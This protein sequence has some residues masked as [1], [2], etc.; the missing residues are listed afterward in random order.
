VNSVIQL[1]PD[2]VANQIAAGEVVQRPASAIKEL[3]ENSLDAGA[4][5][6]VLLIRDGGITS[7]QVVD[8]GRGMSEFDARLCWERHAT[9]KIRRAEDLFSLTTYGFR[10]EAMASIAAVAQVEMKTRR[11]TD[12]YAQFIRIE[13]SEV[14]EQRPEAAPVGTNITIKNLFYNIPARRNFLKSIPVETKHIVEEFMR[15]AM[16]NSH[17][18][19]AFYN[20]QQEVYKFPVQP[21][22]DRL[23]SALGRKKSE[24]LIAVSENT[25]IVRISGFVGAPE[26]AK[27]TRGDQYFF[28]NGRF[29]R[30]SYFHHA[31]QGAY[32]GLI[33]QDTHAMYALF[34]EID[35]AKVDVNVH[36]TK[37]E[38]KFEDEKHLYN[39]LKA[40]VRKSLGSFVIQP[41]LGLETGMG[42]G[43]GPQS[44]NLDLT[45]NP[46]HFE[47]LL[48]AIPSDQSGSAL[49]GNTSS[50]TGS[51]VNRSFNPFKNEDSQPYKREYGQD[52]QRVLGS[53]ET[54]GAVDAGS[55]DRGLQGHDS[56][57]A[58]KEA[59]VKFSSGNELPEQTELFPEEHRLETKGG[60]PLGDLYWVLPMNHKLLI[61]RVQYLQQRLYFEKYRESLSIKKGATQ[62]LLFPRMIELNPSDLALA[63]DLQ[64]E[65]GSLGFDFSHFGGNS[66]IVNGLPPQLSQGDEQ[67]FLEKI[68]EDYLHTGGDVKLDRH[69]S[70]ALTM[71][72]FA[73]SRT[74]G[75]MTEK[76][77]IGLVQELFT[78]PH[79]EVTFDGKV[80]FVEISQSQLFE[81]FNKHRK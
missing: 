9:S 24:D 28:V 32:E 65:L 66:I 63:L 52:W 27:R 36:P 57:N 47:T 58:S 40:A 46:A 22:K 54:D 69:C 38:V 33:D 18:S 62:T 34:L 26:T 4:T 70:L 79:P 68:L 15:Q 42:D 60:F 59:T 73:S 72:R 55:I 81:A 51:A 67:K 10:G 39:L 11:E 44:W 77:I 78:L 19:F 61:F 75:S 8:N 74:P 53:I 17:V 80:I 14:I 71:A 7:M 1:L 50:A 30:S 23:L 31:L 25:E 3:L 12:E 5:D 13:A 6:I 20:N 41:Q 2:A 56:V 48:R 16:A 29:I 76:E 37:T 35:P 49:G 64:S 21:L 43:A 45:S